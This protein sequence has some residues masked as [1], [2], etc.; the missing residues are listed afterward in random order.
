MDTK[1]RKDMDQYK[2]VIPMSND[3]IKKISSNISK[4]VLGASL[5]GAI[6]IGG[7][8]TANAS[9]QEEPTAIVE[10]AENENKVANEKQVAGNN[11]ETKAVEEKPSTAKK[12]S[13]R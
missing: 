5:M 12:N 9:S 3:K 2:I 1:N 6:L 8:S 7:V 13:I 4:S 11:E 10:S